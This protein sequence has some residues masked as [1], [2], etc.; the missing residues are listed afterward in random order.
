VAENVEGLSIL[1]PHGGNF[2]GQLDFVGIAG[3]KQQ[4]T[5]SFGGPTIVAMECL[6]PWKAY[7]ACSACGARLPGPRLR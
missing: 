3:G 2:A 4:L 5:P 6:D 7:A 1:A